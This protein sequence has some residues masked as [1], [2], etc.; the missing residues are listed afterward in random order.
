[1]EEETK[2]VAETLWKVHG[3]LI[4]ERKVLSSLNRFM[5]TKVF[6]KKGSI[7]LS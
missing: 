1:M 6:R 4:R 7:M 3:N 2:R 5:I